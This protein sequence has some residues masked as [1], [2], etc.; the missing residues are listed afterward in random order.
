M[1]KLISESLQGPSSTVKYGLAVK[2]MRFFEIEDTL[3]TMLPREKTHLSHLSS[4]L[5]TFRATYAVFE[6][7]RKD[8]IFQRG[9]F[10]VNA[11]LG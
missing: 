2:K 8:W 10:C 9:G 4:S 6:I 5:K 7:I 11:L 1:Q 3:T